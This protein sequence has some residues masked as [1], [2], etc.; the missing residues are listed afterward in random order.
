MQATCRTS[1]ARSCWNNNFVFLPIPSPFDPGELNPHNPSPN[2]ETLY[3]LNR[4][5]GVSRCPL[6]CIRVRSV[7]VCVSVC[8]SVC[9]SLHEPLD[10]LAFFF[11]FF[12]YSYCHVNQCIIFP[13]RFNK[14]GQ[15]SFIRGGIS[16]TKGGHTNN[17][18]NEIEQQKNQH[19]TSAHTQ[20]NKVRTK[21]TT[22]LRTRNEPWC[23]HGPYHR[24]SRLRSTH[25]YLFR[26]LGNRRN[27]T[28]RLW[29]INNR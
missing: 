29:I 10:I 18:N 6:F 26:V 8:V 7:G 22:T 27:R 1:L 11:T 28:I 3:F 13:R 16:T 14:K 21:T 17:N 25:I 24:Y 15:N 20:H 19:I 4:L 2:P 23:S 12:Y 9:W 5:D